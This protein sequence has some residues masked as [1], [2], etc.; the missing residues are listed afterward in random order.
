MA[1]F[2]GQVIQV[3]SLIILVVRRN[4]SELMSVLSADGIDSQPITDRSFNEPKSISTFSRKLS[5]DD[6]RCGHRGCPGDIS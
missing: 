4:L 6:G 3:E 2:A 5:D 1:T